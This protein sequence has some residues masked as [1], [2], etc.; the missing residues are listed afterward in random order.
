MATHRAIASPNPGELEVV[1][2]KL[3]LRDAPS[4]V[5]HFEVTH[6]YNL[7]LLNRVAHAGR[8]AAR[9]GVGAVVA[10]P[11]NDVRGRR[12]DSDRGGLGGG[13]YLS[14]I[15]GQAAGSHRVPIGRGFALVGERRLTA[16]YARVPIEGG[17]AA[18]PNVAV[19]GLIG[20]GYSWGR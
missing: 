12:L 5:Q 17:C 13:Y 7:I 10:H 2:H 8:W 11:E 16:A 15:A 19:H 6:G 1:H 3:Y 14:G 18:V 9:V 20:I 4:E